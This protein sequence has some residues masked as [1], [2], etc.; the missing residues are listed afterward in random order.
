MKIIEEEITMC[1][2]YIYICRT[3]QIEQKRETEETQ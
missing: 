2:Q 1:I 3:E